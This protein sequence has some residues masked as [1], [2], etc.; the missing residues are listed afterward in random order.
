[1]AILPENGRI[2]FQGF[3]EKQSSMFDS[4]AGWLY[5]TPNNSRNSSQITA[6]TNAAMRGG[7]AFGETDPNDPSHP[8]VANDITGS[9][10]Y[11]FFVHELGNAL[12]FLTGK[13]HKSWFTGKFIY[14]DP[15]LSRTLAK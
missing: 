5:I 3:D 8:Y 6:S 2:S 13:Y 9:M 1:L 4:S 12:A 15:R 11:G 7:V 10:H 14:D